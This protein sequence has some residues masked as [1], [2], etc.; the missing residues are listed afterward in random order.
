MTNIGGVAFEH[1]YALTN[2]FIPASVELLGPAIFYLCTNLVEINVNG[3][4][5]VMLQSCTLTN[6]GIYFTDPDWAN[7]SSRIYRVRAS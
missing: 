5:W 3:A 2:A 7:F 6:G 1:C 4:P